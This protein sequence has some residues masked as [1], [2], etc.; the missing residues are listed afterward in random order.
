MSKQK[1]SRNNMKKSFKSITSKPIINTYFVIKKH[2]NN[3]LQIIHHI[4]HFR[5]SSCLVFLQSMRPI[6][7]LKFKQHVIW[8]ETC[9]LIIHIKF[10]FSLCVGFILTN[11]IF[12]KPYIKATCCLWKGLLET[13]RHLWHLFVEAVNWNLIGRHVL[14][15]LLSN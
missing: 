6:T 15:L 4:W 3:N 14:G 5:I 9:P 13:A 7:N 10:K 11:Q 2:N 8:T 12:K 1:N